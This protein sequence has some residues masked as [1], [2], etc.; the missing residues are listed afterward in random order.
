M[1]FKQFFCYL[2]NSLY[3]RSNLGKIVIDCEGV[4]AKNKFC[5]STNERMNRFNQKLTTGKRRMASTISFSLSLN[6]LLLDYLLSSVARGGF[7][8]A[9]GIDQ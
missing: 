1:V 8:V 7:N 9:Q 4:S 6:D 5:T 2:R 3:N